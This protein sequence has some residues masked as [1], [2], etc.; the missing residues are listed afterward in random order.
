MACSEIAFLQTAE[1]HSGV[2][3]GGQCA[4]AP[5]LGRK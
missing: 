2:Y 5:P 1:A 4:M 3:L